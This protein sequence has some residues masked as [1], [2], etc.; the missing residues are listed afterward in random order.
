MDTDDTLIEVMEDSQ[1]VCLAGGSPGLSAPMPLVRRLFPEDVVDLNTPAPKPKPEVEIP[2]RPVARPLA[3]LKAVL[4][5]NAAKK[6][7]EKEARSESHE[8]KVSSGDKRSHDHKASDDEGSH[9]HKASDDKGSHD[10]KASDDKGSHDHKASDDKGS[11]DKTSEKHKGWDDEK[12]TLPVVDAGGEAP[13]LTRRKQLELQ[14]KGKAKAKAKSM[15][16]ESEPESQMDEAPPAAAESVKPDAK[17]GVDIKEP[18]NAEKAAVC[19]GRGRGKGRGRGRGT[20]ASKAKDASSPR[21]SQNKRGTDGA[22]AMPATGPVPAEISE[23]AENDAPKKRHKGEAKAKAEPKK[24]ATSVPQSL[25][26]LSGSKPARQVSSSKKGMAPEDIMNLLQTDD[27]MMRIVLEQIEAMD[28]PLASVPVRENQENLP[29]Y[30]YWKLSTYWTRQSVG[31][32]RKGLGDMP[33]I[34]VGTLTG[35]GCTTMAVALESLAQ[36]APV[37]V[38]NIQK[39]LSV[40]LNMCV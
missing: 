9:D 20:A 12:G 39:L 13:F 4:A 5:E 18:E 23:A 38:F 25:S 26:V 19:R 21:A 35:G 37:S 1:Q 24:K 14:P 40:G 17:A 29:S 15:A 32:I 16:K 30:K 3:S 8:H 33:D 36:Y 28:K 6:R 7:A 27:L 34:Y 22:E 11:H 10:H 31:V 2:K